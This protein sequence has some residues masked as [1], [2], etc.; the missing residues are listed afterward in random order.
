M[1][2]GS[3]KAIRRWPT[4]AIA[5]TRLSRKGLGMEYF[6]TRISEIEPDPT[7]PK[8]FQMLSRETKVLILFFGYCRDFPI[9]PMLSI[10]VIVEPKPQVV[11]TNSTQ[12]SKLISAWRTVWSCPLTGHLLS[13]FVSSSFGT[14]FFSASETA[15]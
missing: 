3:P 14:S 10:A 15:V 11:A 12:K 13:D 8:K 9:C 2:P 4:Q 6:C 5:R 1:E 7:R